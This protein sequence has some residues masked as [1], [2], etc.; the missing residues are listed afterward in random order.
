MHLT[1]ERPWWSQG[2]LQCDRYGYFR[3]PLLE[4]SSYAAQIHRLVR[5][6]PRKLTYHRL[7]RWY[8]D[9]G[10]LEP[11]FD[12]TLSKNRARLLRHRV[13][14][15]FFDAVVVQADRL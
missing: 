12:S 4:I 3:T 9:M 15:E 8:L 1:W 14:R 7:F 2:Q 10:M 6:C 5:V 13:S 11:S